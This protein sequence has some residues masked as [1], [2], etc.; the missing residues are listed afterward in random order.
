MTMRFGSAGNPRSAPRAGTDHGILRAHALGLQCLEMAWGNGVRMGEA[1]I[2][3][4]AAAGRDTG[5]E[6]T[7][8]APYY[9][10]L[11]GE[12][13]VVRA[14]EER[15]VAAARQAWWCGG[16]S[17]CF[18]AGYYGTLGPARASRR[19]VSAL[20]RITKRLRSEGITLDLRPELTGRSSQAGT[21]E[22][23]VQWSADIEGVKPCIDFAHQYARS[24]GAINRYE[25]FRAMLDLVRDR[26]GATS[27]ASM[28]VH[29]SGIEY[30][31]HGETRHRPLTQSKF[32][33]REVL[34]ALRDAGAA[35]WVIG[36]S[37]EI[38]DDALRLQRAYRRLA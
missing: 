18:H 12:P 13:E 8:H 29:L 19:I 17:V 15:L 37:P 2:A 34:R 9:L 30:R 22:E 6:L 27:L 1:A 26:L 3:R 7:A 20:K 25:D 23:I 16:R 36:E 35:G 14:S 21:L 4:V 11:S 38:E 5:L 28:H 32:R 24:G 33:W 10:N 31:A